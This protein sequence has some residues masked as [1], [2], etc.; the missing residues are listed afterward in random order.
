MEQ[1]AGHKNHNAGPAHADKDG[2]HRAGGGNADGARQ[3]VAHGGAHHAQDQVADQAAA[4][5]HELAGDPAD[6]SAYT[7]ASLPMQLLLLY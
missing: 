1:P 5:A 4:A 2:S 7:F 6:K 3:P